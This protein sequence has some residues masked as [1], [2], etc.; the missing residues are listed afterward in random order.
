MALWRTAAFPSG[1]FGPVLFEALRRL[2]STCLSLV[3]VS[4][5]RGSCT[6]GVRRI[7]FKEDP[8]FTVNL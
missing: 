5:F 2:A 3:M 1:V 8:V 4:P 7:V 6:H